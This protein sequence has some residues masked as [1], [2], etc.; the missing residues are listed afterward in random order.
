LTTFTQSERRRGDALR[1]PE[2]TVEL[3][4]SAWVE[5]T[6]PTAPMRLGLTVPSEATEERID[7]DSEQEALMLASDL[8]REQ[9]VRFYNLAVTRELLFAATTLA[10]NVSQPFFSSPLELQQRLTPGGVERLMDELRALRLS[11]SPAIP[12]IDDAGSSH[13]DAMLIRGVAWDHMQPEEARAC[14]R[15][16]ERCRQELADAEERAEQ[17]GVILAAG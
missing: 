13:L 8:G 2:H 12:E 4:L 10:V 7:K 11:K 15:L 9:Y 5:A 6:R 16:L 17:A 1:K 14:R 3:P